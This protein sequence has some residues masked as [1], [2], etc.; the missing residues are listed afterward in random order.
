MVSR[1]RPA[2]GRRAPAR[3]PPWRA[4]RLRAGQVPGDREATYDGLPA[5]VAIHGPKREPD[6]RAAGGRRDAERAGRARDRPRVAVPP[7]G[8]SRRRRTG[9]SGASILPRD[10]EAPPVERG[11]VVAHEAPRGGSG[12][13]RRAGGA[14]RIGRRRRRRRCGGVFGDRARMSPALAACGAVP[15]VRGRAAAEPRS[16]PAPRRRCGARCGS[17]STAAARSVGAGRGARPRAP[18]R[19]RARARSPP[20]PRLSRRAPRG[21]AG[22]RARPRV[23]S[24]A[25]ATSASR[26]SRARRARPGARTARPPGRGSLSRT[27]AGRPPRWSVAHPT[28]AANAHAALAAARAPTQR[29]RS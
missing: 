15:G 19:P 21:E 22:G 6:G 11:V 1:R 13:L 14:G 23:A 28:I 16:R 2:R 27:G 7:R 29:C 10:R 8:R 24:T 18:A 5:R 25:Q 9:R 4:A 20:S 17:T 12:S 3:P 26:G